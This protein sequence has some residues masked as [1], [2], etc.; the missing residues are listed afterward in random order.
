MSEKGRLRCVISSAEKTTTYE[1]LKSV[2]LPA[3]S[4]SM[5]ILPGH[6]EAFVMIAGGDVA[7]K[8][9]DDKT[10]TLPIGASECHI[11]ND[12]VVIII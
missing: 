5:Q 9:V 11:Q 8:S 6:A 12:E 2:S 7:M 4:G 10:K 1:G 3:S